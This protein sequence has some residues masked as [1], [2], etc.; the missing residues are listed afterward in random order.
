MWSTDKGWAL[1]KQS[2]A[3]T[4]YIYLHLLS[5]Q[6]F[7]CWAR[8]GWDAQYLSYRQ[9]I[10]E[11]FCDELLLLLRSYRSKFKYRLEGSCLPG[12]RIGPPSGGGVAECGTGGGSR[13]PGVSS[14]WHHLARCRQCGRTKPPDRHLLAPGPSTTTTAFLPHFNY[15]WIA[16]KDPLSPPPAN[17]GPMR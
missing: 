1:W 17:L 5:M 10:F 2:T 14:W 3:M 7:C 8:Q 6:N 13:Q 16:R 4:H 9:G 12:G 11:I 15:H